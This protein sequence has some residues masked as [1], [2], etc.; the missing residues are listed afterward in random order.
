MHDVY[1]F[2]TI[3][4]NTDYSLSLNK[5]ILNNNIFPNN[6]IVINCFFHFCQSLIRKMKNLKMKFNKNNGN[7]FIIC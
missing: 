1:N 2:N 6:P 4:I 7:T 3:K 5:A